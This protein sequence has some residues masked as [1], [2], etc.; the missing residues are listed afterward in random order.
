MCF[1]CTCRELPT[2]VGQLFVG[3]YREPF[4]TIDLK[5]SKTTITC[6]VRVSECVPSLQ[7]NKE[8]ASLNGRIIECSWDPHSGWHFMR[9]REDKSFPNSVTTARSKSAPS[10]H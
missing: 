2:K 10:C 8:A 3:G 6:T 5:V 7:L 1:D 9:V 4:S